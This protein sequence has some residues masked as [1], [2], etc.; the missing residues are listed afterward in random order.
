[1]SMVKEY[2]FRA[3][4]GDAVEAFMNEMG[5]Q[6]YVL[7]N[8]QPVGRRINDTETGTQEIVSSFGITM[9]REKPIEIKPEEAAK[10]GQ[11]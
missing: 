11:Q 9:E 6:G 3:V 5:K 2:A 1:M 4:A 10:T 8:I 7:V